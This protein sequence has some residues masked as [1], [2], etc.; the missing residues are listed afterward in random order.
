MHEEHVDGLLPSHFEQ[1]EAHFTANWLES[2]PN[3]YDEIVHVI[4][5]IEAQLQTSH[6]LPHIIWEP[7]ALHVPP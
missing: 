7:P 2:N 4:A 3:P 1:P 5:L 6:P